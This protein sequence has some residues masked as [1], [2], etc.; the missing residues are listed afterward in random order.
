MCVATIKY[1]CRVPIY[2]FQ[3]SNL[4]NS[5]LSIF[6][7]FCGV[8]LCLQGATKYC[9]YNTEFY[10]YFYHILESLNMLAGECPSEHV[11]NIS[12]TLIQV[13][14]VCHGYFIHLEV[15]MQHS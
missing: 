14:F 1:E 2:V 8:K 9:M 6:L 11:G 5:H 13:W 7:V 10:A 3:V 15:F 12:K 4:F